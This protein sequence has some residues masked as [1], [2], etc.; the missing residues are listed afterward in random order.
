MSYQIN[1]VPVLHAIVAER[2]RQ[3]SLKAA[4]K[5][6]F[7]CA[8]E[9]MTDGECLAVI[10]EEIGEVAHEVNEVIGRR[11]TQGAR[12]AYRARLRTELIQVAAV[13]T[14]WVERLDGMLR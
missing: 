2:D 4:G 6:M 12:E 3:E 1:T 7:T 5:F 10:V 11:L 14:A 8:D 9:A 13:A